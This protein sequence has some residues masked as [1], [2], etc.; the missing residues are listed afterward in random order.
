MASDDDRSRRKRN[1][2]RNGD[3]DLVEKCFGV[4]SKSVKVHKVVENELES[5]CN[6][7]HVVS[8][9]QGADLTK[10]KLSRTRGLLIAVRATDTPA[11]RSSPKVYDHTY[12][13]VER[14]EAD[15]KLQKNGNRHANETNTANEQVE[16]LTE[17]ARD[18]IKK[19][20]PK[21]DEKEKDFEQKRREIIKQQRHEKEIE[22]REEKLGVRPEEI[23]WTGFRSI[24]DRFAN[25]YEISGRI[26][27]YCHPIEKIGQIVGFAER[28]IKNAGRKFLDG[29]DDKK[30]K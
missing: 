24:M 28:C 13:R 2:S 5:I 19:T 18:V 12:I 15:D 20:T 11:E 25:C 23:L 8:I 6:G 16:S 9:R 14:D 21:K 29:N 22:Q 27:S 10:E 4:W 3:P 17:R 1:S 26:L 7:I 30:K